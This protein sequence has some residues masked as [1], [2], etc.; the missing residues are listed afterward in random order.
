M[1]AEVLDSL[2]VC[3]YIFW[4]CDDDDGDAVDA[5]DACG[6][7]VENYGNNRGDKKPIAK[8]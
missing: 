8:S 1:G 2:G 4:A 7:P 6:K 3:G 5:V